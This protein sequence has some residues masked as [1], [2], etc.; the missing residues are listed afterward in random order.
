[1]P[2]GSR[3]GPSPCLRELNEIVRALP[4]FAEDTAVRVREFTCTGPGCP[5]HES[6]VAALPMDDDTAP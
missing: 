1:M 6:V 3:P 5:P 2:L 4:G